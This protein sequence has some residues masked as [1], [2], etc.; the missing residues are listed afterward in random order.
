MNNISIRDILL[1]IG[2]AIVLTIGLVIH[3]INSTA[4]TPMH[5][6]PELSEGKAVSKLCYVSE[7]LSIRFT[8]EP[9]Y[10]R[11]ELH[12]FTQMYLI[13]K[14]PKDEEKIYVPYRVS[15]E[16]FLKLMDELPEE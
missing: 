5:A 2:G 3:Y 13:F 11:G 7:G 1:T 9:F 12:Y 8:L 15:T 14:G 10:S 6:H 4:H 16:E